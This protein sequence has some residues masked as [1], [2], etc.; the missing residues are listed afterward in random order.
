[1]DLFDS[2][3]WRGFRE[4][5]TSLGRK[6]KRLDRKLE[7][8]DLDVTSSSSPAPRTAGSYAPSI[9]L[10]SRLITLKSSCEA[11]YHMFRPP[12]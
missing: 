7:F 6:G 2:G 4:S 9:R 10:S 3:R 11:N 1:M 5:K 8:E 12:G